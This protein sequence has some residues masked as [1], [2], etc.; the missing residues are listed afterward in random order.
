M[1][2]NAIHI[3]FGYWINRSH[4][5]VRWF[6][7]QNLSITPGW[8]VG[9]FFVP[10]FNLFRP[11]VAMSELHKSSH[12]PIAWTKSDSGGLTSL[13]WALWI[14][15]GFLGQIAFRIAVGA[16]TLPEIQASTVAQLVS[17]VA[18]IPLSLVAFFL[19]S[20]IQKA[21]QRWVDQD[22]IQKT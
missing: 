16:D 12:N 13:W 5:N 18:E 1:P 3:V 14:L 15:A 8:A 22:S 17:D 4:Q 20:S 10:I 21:Q 9:Y 7:A 19:V 2:K 6:G 11:Y